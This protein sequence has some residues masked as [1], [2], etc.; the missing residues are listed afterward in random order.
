MQLFEFLIGG[1]V[2]ARDWGATYPKRDTNKTR[3]QT[4][5]PTRFGGRLAG[6]AM[7]T[8]RW[9]WSCTQRLGILAPGRMQSQRQILGTGATITT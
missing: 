2:W 8:L 5:D 4:L 6:D 9:R 7:R 1:D 3:P